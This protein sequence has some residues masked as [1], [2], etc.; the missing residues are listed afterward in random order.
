MFRSVAAYFFT[1]HFPCLRSR[2][3]LQNRIDRVALFILPGNHMNM[4][5][6]DR[7]SSFDSKEKYLLPILLTVLIGSILITL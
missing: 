2:V 5:K 7:K 1:P 3:E 6:E 4:N